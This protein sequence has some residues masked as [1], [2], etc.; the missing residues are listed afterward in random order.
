MKRIISLALVLSL[1]GCKRNEMFMR[2]YIG[3]YYG[4]NAITL[5]HYTEYNGIIVSAHNLSSIGGRGSTGVQKSAYDALCERHGDMSY[6]RKIKYMPNNPPLP[7]SK[8]AVDF[9]SVDIVSDADYDADHPAGESLGDVVLFI[10]STVKPF[11]DSGYR[12]RES[13]RIEKYVSELSPDDL[14][15]LGG[16]STYIPHGYIINYL[17]FNFQP[18]LSKTHTFTVT[19]TADDGRV[20]SDSI[21]MT[22]E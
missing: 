14:I 13:T 9:V 10:S 22:F 7:V 17:M 21:E 5:H 12:G 20:F 4:C 2:S 3:S 15:L 8:I 19:M 18:T 6:N 11:I 16:N 1:F